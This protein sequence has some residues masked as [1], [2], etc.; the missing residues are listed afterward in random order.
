[1]TKR[2]KLEGPTLKDWDEVDQRLQEQGLIDLQ[3]QEIEGEMNLAIAAAKEI[4]KEKSRLLDERSKVIA[5]EVKEYTD[6]HRD[7]I[8]GKE[9]VLIFGK[10]GYRKSTKINVP[11]KNIGSIIKALLTRGL[12]SCVRI[13]QEVNKD[14]IRALPDDVIAEIGCTKKVEDVFF[15]EADHEKI[16]QE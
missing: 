11:R 1:M 7:E 9:K 15:L 14:A 6:H 13:T 2:I 8:K 3:L 5:R 4:A 12:E 16:R 10:V